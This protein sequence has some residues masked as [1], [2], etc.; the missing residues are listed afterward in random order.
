MKNVLIFGIMIYGFFVSSVFAATTYTKEQLNSMVTAGSY[1]D[2]LPT[3]TRSA[4][5]MAFGQCKNDAFTM[6]SQIVGDYPAQVI[7]DTNILYMVKLWTNDGAITISCSEP[8][9]KRIVTQA[10]YR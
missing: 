4:E 7:I 5:S 1:P 9:V 2:Q 6:Y 10:A 3:V 8:D